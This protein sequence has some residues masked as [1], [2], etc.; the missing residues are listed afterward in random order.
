MGCSPEARLHGAVAWVNLYLCLNWAPGKVAVGKARFW[1]Q[2]EGRT[3]PLEA[4]RP[5]GSQHPS[6]SV[7]LSPRGVTH[8]L[9][10]SL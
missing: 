5:A 2:Q 7:A 1:C 3:Q 4:W 9:G 6:L 10:L 8:L